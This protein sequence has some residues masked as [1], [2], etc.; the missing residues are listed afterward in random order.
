MDS[1]EMELKELDRQLVRQA[2]AQFWRM[3]LPRERI[4]ICD[5]VEHHVDLTYDSTSAE[6]GHIQL[7][8]YQ[9]EPLAATELDGCQEVTLC[10]G[11]R[12][13]KSTIWKMSL[14]KHVA[15]GGLSCVRCSYGVSVAYWR[16]SARLSPSGNR[17][18]LAA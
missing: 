7:Y 8:P 13:G 15:D 17:G 2:C 18:E 16:L 1:I 10:W 14:L 5:W 9:R 11:Q 3:L 6:S 12:M 4:P